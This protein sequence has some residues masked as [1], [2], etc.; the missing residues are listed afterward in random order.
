MRLVDAVRLV[1]SKYVTF[2]GRAGRGEFWWWVLAMVLAFIVVSGL[3][4]LLFD[5]DEAGGGPLSAVL[6]LATF[7]PH[8]AVSARRLHDIDRTGWWLLLSFV[9]VVGTLVLLY[10][11]VLAG[12][13]GSNRFGPPP[14]AV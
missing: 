12:T 4:G 10:F 13:P 11:Y 7:L 2:S 8:L 5:S 14:P 1:F 9:P 3:D 6:V